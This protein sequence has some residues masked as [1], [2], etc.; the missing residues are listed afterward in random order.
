MQMDDIVFRAG[1]KNDELTMKLP[2][3]GQLRGYELILEAA[4]EER[5][6]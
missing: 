1:F 6:G 5:K 2:D 3:G 4:A